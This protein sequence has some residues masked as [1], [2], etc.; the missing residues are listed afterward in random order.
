MNPPSTTDKILRGLWDIQNEMG[1]FCCGRDPDDNRH[2]QRNGVSRFCLGA[3]YRIHHILHAAGLDDRSA[4]FSTTPVPASVEE[5]ILK[6]VQDVPDFSKLFPRRV[7]GQY[8][9]QGVAQAH[10]ELL[11]RLG[12]EMKYTPN[13]DMTDCPPQKPGGGESPD[14]GRF[15][16]VAVEPKEPLTPVDEA[17]MDD[18]WTRAKQRGKRVRDYLLQR[19]KPTTDR[20]YR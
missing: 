15:H 1:L 5:A 20:L 14:C 18:I 7:C 10:Q 13:Y 8:E 4:D 9:A 16:S 11:R 12:G 3:Y 19:V 17:R 6:V 2:A